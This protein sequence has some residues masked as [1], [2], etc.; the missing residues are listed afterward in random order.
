MNNVIGNIVQ[1][2]HYQTYSPACKNC[3]GNGCENWG[4]SAATY[5]YDCSNGDWLCAY[6]KCPVLWICPDKPVCSRLNKSNCDI[7]LNSEKN[8]P[9]VNAY[10]NGAS[11]NVSCVFDKTKIDTIPQLNSWISKFGKSGDYN[12]IISDISQR[13]HTDNCMPNPITK[14]TPKQCS[15]LFQNSDMG[16]LSRD[17]FNS[18]S[19]ADKDVIIKSICDKSPTLVECQCYSRDKDPIYKKLKP[20][21]MDDDTTPST[22]ISDACWW[23]TCKGDSDRFLLYSDVVNR[24][25]KVTDCRELANQMIANNVSKSDV[26]NKTSCSFNY[27]CTKDNNKC[28]L[29]SCTDTTKPNCYDKSNCNNICS[30]PLPPPSLPPYVVLGGV[31][32]VIVVAV[33]LFFF[34]RI[35]SKHSI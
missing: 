20:P 30:P 24:N 9:L 28:L 3:N 1:K 11:P 10:W 16:K 18:M 25:C 23:K 32:I 33:V 35:K 26:E 2:D 5:W 4:C 19:Q 14:E 13:I 29:T 8:T 21:I 15:T 31:G 22:P 17:W 12:K 34:I 7:G 27:S 6:K